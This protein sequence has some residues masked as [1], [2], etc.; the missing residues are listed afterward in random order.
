MDA[1]F[2][3]FEKR[4]DIRFEALE[5]R[6]NSRFNSLSLVFVRKIIAAAGVAATVLP[7][8]QACWPGNRQRH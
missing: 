4:I 7:A 6:M 1:R 3:A 5:N 2:E 8:S